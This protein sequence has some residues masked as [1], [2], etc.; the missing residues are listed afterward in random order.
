MVISIEPIIV[1]DKKYFSIQ[2]M[3]SI[4]NKSEQTI[5]GLINRGNAMRKMK[6]IKI[7]DRT[8]IPCLELTEFPFTYAGSNPKE[9]TYHYNKEGKVIG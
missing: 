3:A 6:H 9:N 1:G 8:L 4:T 5:Y 7:L 2:Q